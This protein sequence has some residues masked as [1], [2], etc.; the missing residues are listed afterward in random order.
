MFACSCVCVCE[1]ISMHMYMSGNWKFP[2]A[3][4]EVSLKNDFFPF[5][6]FI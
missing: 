6:I 1:C 4:I 2:C 3:D 5:L